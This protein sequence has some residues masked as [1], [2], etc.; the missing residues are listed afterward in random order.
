M[1]HTAQKLVVTLVIAAILFSMLPIIATA[2]PE[3]HIATYVGE[4]PE[5]LAADTSI[6]AS[7]FMT[8]YDAVNVTSNGI[9]YTVEI[10]PRGT[11]Y[12]VD[13]IDKDETKN[14]STEAYDAVKA[15]LGDRL[16]NPRNDQYKTEEN[17]WGLM[18]CDVGVKSYTGSAD[19]MA[20]G[21]YGAQNAAGETISYQFHLPAGVYR[22]K[23][24]HT[25]WWNTSRP[26]STKIELETGKVIDGRNI[27]LSGSARLYNEM[28]FVLDRAQTI[29]YTITAT[30][31]QAPVISYV[32]IDKIGE[33]TPPSGEA[34]PKPVLP[35][36][37]Y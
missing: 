23:S 18:D 16:L 31:S 7:Q 21:Y 6:T 1:K 8:P 19:K 13:S 12:F 2:A 29:T 36:G 33:Y 14:A 3:T 27:S 32:A 15:L 34:P 25:E 11:V 22:L 5:I 26:M 30:G 20:N 37:I 28:G 35:E 10:V 17:T 4:V 9:T 24:G